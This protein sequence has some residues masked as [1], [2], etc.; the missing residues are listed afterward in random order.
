MG[1][2]SLPQPYYLYDNHVEEQCYSMVE[3]GLIFLYRLI[4]LT[5]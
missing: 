2:P 5:Q 4:Y 3:Y 1:G